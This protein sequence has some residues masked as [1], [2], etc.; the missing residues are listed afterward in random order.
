MGEGSKVETN[1]MPGAD[2]LVNRTTGLAGAQKAD[3]SKFQIGGP[4]MDLVANQMNVQPAI[5]SQDTAPVI[6][7]LDS[8][9]ADFGNDEKEK[10]WRS[11]TLEKPNMSAAKTT[12]DADPKDPSMELILNA[13]LGGGSKENMSLELARSDIPSHYLEGMR[14]LA[15]KDDEPDIH[16]RLRNPYVEST[17]EDI[18]VEKHENHSTTIE[19]LE[20][21]KIIDGYDPGTG[22]ADLTDERYSGFA[23]KVEGQKGE[24]K[25]YFG[26]G[27][28]R[29]EANKERKD[30]A[31]GFEIALREFSIR[32]VIGEHVGLSMSGG[33]RDSL[34]GLTET[35]HTRA[36][37][38]SIPQLQEIWNL[39][40]IDR[41]DVDINDHTFGKQIEEAMFCYEIML[42]SATK[43]MMEEFL[44]RPGAKD[45]IT[46]L[47]VKAGQ[48]E[49]KWKLDNIGDLTKWVDDNKRTLLSYMTDSRGEL[50][51]HSNIASYEAPNG[52]KLSYDN[53]TA[54]INHVGK[55]V[56][57]V[58]ASWFGGSILRAFGEFSS[59][60]F[61]LL[62]N[63]EFSLALGESQFIS[64]DDLGKFHIFLYQLKEYMKKRP[65]GPK[66]LIGKIPDIALS[67]LDTAQVD[68]IYGKRS[69]MDA[70]LG[71]AA[72]YKID[73]DTGDLTK[74]IIKEESGTRLGE[75]KFG[76]LQRGAHNTHLLMNWL[77][78]R[79]DWGIVN[80]IMKNDFGPGDLS[81]NNQKKLLKYIGIIF[82]PG[83]LS[84]GSPHKYVKSSAKNAP[85]NIFNRIY[86]ARK[87][88]QSYVMNIL[89]AGVKLF[90][91]SGTN[92]PGD[93]YSAALII[94]EGVR[95]L[96]EKE[97]DLA[98]IADS[99]YVDADADLK[100]NDK[101]KIQNAK[102]VYSDLN[103]KEVDRLRA[104]HVNHKP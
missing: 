76:S 94:D 39:P 38:L 74:E 95:T 80:Q 82:H 66:D 13:L 77:K 4:N 59:K 52:D 88:T 5:I 75:L 96:I 8:S 69:M 102:N 45:L 19:K 61:V 55:L 104:E 46:R 73:M 51:K 65:S 70:W 93:E 90:N 17:V 81:L 98:K 101:N 47:A 57:S 3:I 100:K 27:A 56:G 92:G 23:L 1:N 42:H 32:K 10:E 86:N 68:T 62:P 43:T 89:G 30:K 63:G 85:M 37:K 9:T 24:K 41:V 44:A 91:P 79:E 64:S 87:L 71:T 54:F 103:Q 35:M 84:H 58:E 12:P 40:S 25:Y 33:L 15:K 53:E 34:E 50:T 18:F 78:G 67:F 7:D 60:G 49:D 11:R 14:R 16:D 48:T 26:K 83:T 97:P 6:N 31:R 99:T 20:A 28:N 22:Y 29:E 21:M 36:S 2:L 72:G